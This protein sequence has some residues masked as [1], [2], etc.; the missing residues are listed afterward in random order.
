[1]T[2]PENGPI[3]TSVQF[4]SHFILQ[5][6]NYPTM[7]QAVL[8]AGENI[9]R[10]VIMCVGCVTPR[11]QVDKFADVF[12]AVNKKYPQEL[13]AW[14]KVMH[15]TNFPTPLVNETEK[16]AFVSQIIREKV[17]KRLIQKHLNDF[18]V[19]A[20]GLSEKYQ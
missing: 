17:N 16:S 18:A 13:V 15:T 12:L 14:M 20:R 3:R 9:I 6:R 2:L 19:I 10:T 8:D 11:S 7:T 4:L 1:M 5:S